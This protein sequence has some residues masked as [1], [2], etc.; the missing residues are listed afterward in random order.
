MASVLRSVICR[1][2]YSTRV[3]WLYGASTTSTAQPRQQPENATPAQV[4]VSEDRR[5]LTL[6]F[7]G[8]QERRF[9]GI[10]L[11]HNCRC[12]VCYSHDNYMSLVSYKQLIGAELS[13]ARVQG[14][15]LIRCG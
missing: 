6:Q 1:A 2:K 14:A 5:K 12:P 9:H 7:E 4:A 3:R 13:S 15:Q 8:E 10:W 11:R